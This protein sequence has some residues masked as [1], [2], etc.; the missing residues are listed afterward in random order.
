MLPDGVVLHELQPHPD[1][2]GVFTELFRCSW[3]LPVTPVQWNVVSTAQN[4]FRGVHAH[5]SHEDYLIVV[6][7]HATVGVHDLREGS[8]TEGLGATVEMSGEAPEAI[9]IPTGVAHGFF[10]HEPSLHVYAMTSEWSP[11]G[12]AGCRW[13]D[14]ELDIEWPCADPVLSQRDRD[15]GSVSQL[16]AVV[17]EALATVGS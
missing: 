2:R 7:G 14:P 8:P 6:A 16:R 17:R 13:D 4:V 9:V 11:A 3:E 1:S 10:F 5:W 15:L 12:D